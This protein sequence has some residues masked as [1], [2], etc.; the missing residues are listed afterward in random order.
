M[1]QNRVRHLEQ[2]V[3]LKDERIE[4]LTTRL[5]KL[6]QVFNPTQSLS[7]SPVYVGLLQPSDEEGLGDADE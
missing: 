1:L 3:K 6:A 2:T 7:L 5:D 4:Q